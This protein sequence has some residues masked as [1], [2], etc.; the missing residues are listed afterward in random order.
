MRRV[1][2]RH[3]SLEEIA[4]GMWRTVGQP[5][6]D[7]YALESAE[8]MRSSERFKDAMLRAVEEWPVSCEHNLTAV[9]MNRLAWVGH[10]GCCVTLGAP[11]DATRQGWHLLD[12]DE[13][14]EANRVAME[15]IEEWELA[16]KERKDRCQRS[17]LELMY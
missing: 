14:R 16:Y 12:E 13:Q 4:N 7:A 10:A 17:L 6:R 3:D 11:E 8:L 15:A 9:S 5:E 2:H 1:Y